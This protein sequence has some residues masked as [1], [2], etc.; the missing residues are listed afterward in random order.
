[1][2]P[3]VEILKSACQFQ[4]VIKRKDR[5]SLRWKKNL[6]LIE[7]ISIYVFTSTSL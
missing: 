4:N 1:M 3:K 6:K 2:I 7:F 5:D